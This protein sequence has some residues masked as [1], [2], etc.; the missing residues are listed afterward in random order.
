[1][2][3]TIVRKSVASGLYKAITVSPSVF[4]IGIHTDKHIWGG[5]VLFCNKVPDPKVLLVLI[6][7][8]VSELM[9]FG[10]VIETRSEAFRQLAEKDTVNETRDDKF[11][12]LSA[13]Q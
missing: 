2:Q 8:N 7:A 11:I 3:S 6:H 13:R 9:R 4:C 10:C 5:Q 1:M 12:N